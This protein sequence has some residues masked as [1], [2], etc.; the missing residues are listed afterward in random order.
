MKTITIILIALFL[1]V[2]IFLGVVLVKKS[3][4]DKKIADLETG[5]IGQTLSDTGVSKITQDGSSSSTDNT[6]AS[7]ASETSDTGAQTS[8]TAAET[9]AAPLSDKVEDIQIYLDG[10]KDNGIFLGKAEYGLPSSDAALIYGQDFAD[11]GFDLKID[12]SKYTF[13]PGSVHTLYIYVNIPASGVEY[14][15]EEITIPGQANLSQTIKMSI[16]SIGENEIITNDKL[17]EIRISGW[18]A[19]LNVREGTG[20]SKVEVFLDGPSGFGKKLGDAQINLERTDVGNIYGANFNNCGYSFSFDGSALEPGSSHKLFVY[21]ISPG[22]SYQYIP[23]NITIEGAMPESNALVNANAVFNANSLDINGWAINK[24]Y[25]SQGVPRPTD[26]NYA[27]KKVVFVSNKSGNEDIWSMNLD[28]S[29]LAQLT[30]DPGSDQ[31]P[32]ISPDGK[33]IA[34]SAD[35]GGTWQIVVMNWDGTNKQQITSGPNRHGFPTWA[36]DGKYIFIEIYIDENWEMFVMDSDGKNLKRLTNNPG[37]EDWHPCAHPFEYKVIYESGR[38]DS[39][40]IWEIDINGKNARRIS[41]PGMRYRVPK[42][43]ID[44]QKI[45]FMGY[46]GNGTPQAFLMDYSGENVT[47]ITNIEAG[48]GI[49][50]ISPDNKLI[51]FST[52][53]GAAEIFVMNID[54]SSLTQL[55][56]FA[57][58]DWGVVFMYQVAE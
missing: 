52:S 24:K 5:D 47:Q 8:D 30:N 4:N 10:D 42:V 28:G 51:A 21:A 22:G 46:D 11:F 48:A 1:S 41:K 44:G 40:E 16:D 58:D 39:E 32:A 27:M 45:L 50:S 29:E 14:F 9:T 17:K 6:G 18:A 49:P 55:T 20:I 56:N 2:S 38:V 12:S 7:T 57:G 54:G 26:I 36:F 35:I 13:E 23:R 43:S 19:D 53:G 3:V 31:Y 34:Y 15:K 33:K 37:I 25:V